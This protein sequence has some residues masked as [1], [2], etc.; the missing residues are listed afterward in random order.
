MIAL[1]TNVLVRYLVDDDATQSGAARA[2][3]AELTLESPG[4]VCREVLVELVWVLER[5]YGFPRDRIASVLES[6]FATAVLRIET[7]DDVVRAAYG[8]R[9]GGAEFADRMIAAAGADGRGRGALHVRPAGGAAGRCNTAARGSARIRPVRGRVSRC[10]AGPG[11]G[12]Y[13]LGAAVA[14]W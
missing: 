5:A 10:A 6:L 1:D 13:R 3:I 14:Q 12:R 7:A 2:L 9:R 8:Y 11:C 4:F